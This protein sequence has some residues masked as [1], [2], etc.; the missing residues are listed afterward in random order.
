MIYIFLELVHAALVY[1]S[2]RV[3]ST[4]PRYEGDQEDTDED[5]QQ[6]YPFEAVALS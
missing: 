4:A 3:S 5:A 1:V 6:R 2:C